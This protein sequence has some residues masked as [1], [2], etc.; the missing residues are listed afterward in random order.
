MAL[1]RFRLKQE[2]KPPI[3][4][5]TAGMGWPVMEMKNGELERPQY[6][7]FRFLGRRERNGPGRRCRPAVVHAVGLQLYGFGRAA[8]R[9][10]RAA[11]L[12]I[13]LYPIDDWQPV[14]V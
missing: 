3:L 10:R 14:D 4:L 2:R 12:P 6:G 13:G 5:H 8:D 11:G 1:V 9:H 7:G